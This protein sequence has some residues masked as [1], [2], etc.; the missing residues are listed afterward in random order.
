MRDIQAVLFDMDGVV[1]DTRQSVAAFWR[2]FAAERGV[3]LSP[4]D[5]ADHVFGVPAGHTL[6]ALFPGVSLDAA[7]RERVRD[8]EQGLAYVEVPG[9]TG[10]VGCLRVGGVPTALVTSG[11]GWKVEAM[12]GQLGLAG[13]FDAVV[14]ATDVRRG[15]PDPEGYALA[16]RRLG[17]PGACCLVFEDS[18]SGVRAAVAAGSRC[19]GVQGGRLARRLL[20]SGAWAVVADF[21]S[22]RVASRRADKPSEAGWVLPLRGGLSLRCVASDA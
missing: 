20:D 19:I 18:P 8:Y 15:K 12:A 1:I 22:L 2:A 5:F 7:F 21:T 10:F 6:T 11:E 17:V 9:L 3:T 4:D 14:T 13:A 16:A